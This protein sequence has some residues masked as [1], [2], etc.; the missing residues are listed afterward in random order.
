MT[1]KSFRKRLIWTL[2]VLTSAIFGTIAIA[3][4]LDARVDGNGPSEYILA[5]IPLYIVFAAAWLSSL[6]QRRIAYT[7]ALRRAVGQGWL[8]SVQ[9]ARQYTFLSAP[10]PE[11]YA[12]VMQKP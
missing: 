4:W 1:A 10:K 2:A 11:D 6:F 9:Q 8:Q 7:N 5:L 12:S 3:Y